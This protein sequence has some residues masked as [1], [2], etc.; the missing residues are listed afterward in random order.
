VICH[1]QK[2]PQIWTVNDY[3]QPTTLGINRISDTVAHVP[4]SNGNE[5]NGFHHYFT[6]IFFYFNYSRTPASITQFFI[7]LARWSARSWPALF[8]VIVDCSFLIFST[9]LPLPVSILFV[10]H[11]GYEWGYQGQGWGGIVVLK[12]LGKDKCF[13][14]LLKWL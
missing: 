11:H 2:E 12:L 7:I 9:Q 13:G 8:K 4:Q 5:L 14:W 3:P 6:N 1:K 10:S